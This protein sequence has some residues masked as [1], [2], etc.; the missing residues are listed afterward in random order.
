MEKIFFKEEQRFGQWWLWLILGIATLV[1]TGPVAWG[2]YSQEV[3]GKP[4]GNKPAETNELVISLVA[5][6]AIMSSVLILIRLSKLKTEIR[7]DGLWFYYRPFFRKWRCIKPSE[8][9]KYEVRTYNASREFG[10]YG[11]QY[12]GKKHGRAFNVSGNTG[13]QLYL[14]NGK[15]ILIGTQRKQAIDYAMKKMMEPE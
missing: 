12:G 11:L 15:K 13:L 4:F 2:I 6:S 1:S 10:G 9:E 7:P 8:I 3:L 5:I 14:K